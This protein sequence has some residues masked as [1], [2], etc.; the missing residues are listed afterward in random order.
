MKKNNGKN[1]IRRS[2]IRQIISAHFGGNNSSLRFT[3]LKSVDEDFGFDFEELLRSSLKSLDLLEQFPFS[4]SAREIELFDSFFNDYITYDFPIETQRSTATI[5]P[6][7]TNLRPFHTEGNSMVDAGIFD[8]D[9]VL[10]EAGK[11]QTGDIAVIRL[12]DKFF[13]KR[14][15]VKQNGWELVSANPKYEPIEIDFNFDF[16]IIGRVKYIMRKIN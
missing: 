2:L 5:P 13:V 4:K 9:I 16:E 15:I 1:E 7:A 6:S 12:F 10:V 11:F 8:G 3:N 14:V